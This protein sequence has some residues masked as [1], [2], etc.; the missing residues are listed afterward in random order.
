[1]IV[2]KTSFGYEIIVPETENNSEFRYQVRQVRTLNAHFLPEEE[3]LIE[4]LERR[5]RPLT[6]KLFKR[7]AHME[8]LFGKLITRQDWEQWEERHGSFNAR[9]HH[10]IENIIWQIDDVSTQFCEESKHGWCF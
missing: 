1:M 6:K 7:I 3:K 2:N 8:R 5:E 9:F 10:A 4:R